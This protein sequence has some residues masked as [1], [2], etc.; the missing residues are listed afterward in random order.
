MVLGHAKENTVLQRELLQYG[1]KACWLPFRSK[2]PIGTH[3]K[4]VPAANH[5]GAF[6][7]CF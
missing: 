1:A 2:F 3:Y 7:M 6:G 4:T 5:M